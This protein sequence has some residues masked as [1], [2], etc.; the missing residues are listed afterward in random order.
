MIGVGLL[1]LPLAVRYAGW[2]IGLSFL[3]FSAVATSYTASILAKCL[4]V[5]DTLIT[6]AD[7]AYVS[8]G[9]RARVITSI[10]FGLDLIGVSV[11]LVVLFADSLTALMPDWNPID[12]KLLCAV[13]L[14]PLGFLP[15]WIL[16]FSSVLGILCCLGSTL[17]LR[18]IRPG[19]ISDA[20]ELTVVVIICI[21]GLIKP[22]APGSLREPAKTYLFPSDWSMLPL[23]IGLLMCQ[24]F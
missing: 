17:P 8:F 9:Q 13:A 19:A 4:D 21:D 2:V 22:H 7:V 15:L 3:F 6:F 18:P 23:A 11:A 20:D 24:C 16:S 12:L 1:S 5:D 10:L 14:I